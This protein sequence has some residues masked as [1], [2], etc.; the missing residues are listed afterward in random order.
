MHKI[1]LISIFSLIALI[2]C[3]KNGELHLSED[4]IEA[5]GNDQQELRSEITTSAEKY[6][7]VPYKD[8]GKTPQ[9]GFDCSGYVSYIFNLHNIIYKGSASQ[10]SKLGVY[11][12]RKLLQPGDLVFF[13]NKVG[14]TLVTH[15][16][17]VISNINNEV[18]MIH[19]S[20]TYGISIVNLEKSTYWNSRFL[21]GKDI[22]NS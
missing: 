22:L 10:M 6:L 9:T 21:F 12:D 19:S 7:G 14:N 20:V 3:G 2:G 18:K 17:M 4:V 8:N 13:T 1:I 5:V 15:M 16:G 11:K